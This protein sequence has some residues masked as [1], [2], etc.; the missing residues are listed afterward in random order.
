MPQA[1]PVGGLSL[2]VHI[3]INIIVYLYKKIVKLFRL[4]SQNFISKMFEKL[5]NED[6]DTVFRALLSYFLIAFTFVAVISNFVFITYRLI[7]T[8]S[9]KF[10]VAKNDDML[11]YSVANA[12]ADHII[13]VASFTPILVPK[14]FKYDDVEVKPEN[15]PKKL[16]LNLVDFM[17][18]VGI[19]D[20]S[21]QNR[22][23]LALELGVINEVSEYR[24]SSVQNNEIIEKFISRVLANQQQ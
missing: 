22:S 7:E 11:N 13:E 3:I 10:Y 17:R 20:T 6:G 21:F 18:I 5:V 23:K 19:L 24:G 15:L 4:P 2:V 12:E 16:D 8:A 1:T 9:E 14:Y